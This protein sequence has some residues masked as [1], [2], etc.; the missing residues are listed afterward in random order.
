MVKERIF[1]VVLV[2]KDHGAGVDL[3]TTHDSIVHYN[4]KAVRIALR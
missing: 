2:S 4:G 1:N 3:A